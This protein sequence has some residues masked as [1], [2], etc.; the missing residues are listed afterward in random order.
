MIDAIIVDL[1]GIATLLVALA[2]IVVALRALPLTRI[3][4]SGLVFLV[5]FGSVVGSLYMSEILALPPCNLCWWQRIFIYPIA[6]ISAV[7]LIRRN[8]TNLFTNVSVLSVLGLLTALVNI[9]VQTYPDS[10]GLFICDPKNPCSEIDVI[11]LNFLTLP[12][13]SAVAFLF[14]LIC[15][16]V[17]SPDPSNGDNT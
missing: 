10:G 4:L 7:A 17:A 3:Q 13:M 15:A 12:M 11:A 14:F 8:T 6:V 16:W 1:A 9:Y 5:S 2:G